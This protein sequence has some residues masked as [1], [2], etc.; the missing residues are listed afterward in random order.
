MRYSK[1]YIPTVKDGLSGSAAI[2]IY[3]ALK[4][5][6]YNVLLDDKADRFAA[7]LIDAELMGIP[8][9]ITVGRK[10][11]EEIVE[12][13][14]RKRDMQEAR[15]NDILEILVDYEVEHAEEIS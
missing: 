2:Q 15:I 5:L 1:I 13:K 7:K 12:L 10:I 9:R 4:A 11:S 8:L 6:N 14:Y 3:D